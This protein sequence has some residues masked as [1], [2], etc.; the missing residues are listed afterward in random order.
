MQ[1]SF[2]SSYADHQYNHRSSTATC[3]HLPARHVCNNGNDYYSSD[4]DYQHQTYLDRASSTSSFSSTSSACSANYRI[5]PVRYSA[6]V[7]RILPTV[8]AN[9]RGIN[10]RIRFSRPHYHHHHHRHRRHN[11]E[12]YERSH[13]RQMTKEQQQYGSCP[14]LNGTNQTPTKS[15]ITYIETRSVVRGSSNDRLNTREQS[16][17]KSPIANTRIKHIPLKTN[18]VYTRVIRENEE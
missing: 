13:H 8:T 5:L 12:E 3:R 7:D 6:S 10:V 1:R 17:P 2:S 11:F 9:E 15:N 4:T 16:I 18:T 14:V